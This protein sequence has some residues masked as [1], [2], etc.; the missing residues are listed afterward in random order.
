M[1]KPLKITLIVLSNIL[2]LLLIALLLVSPIAKSYIEKHD[3]ELIGRELTIDKLRV[4]LLGGKV[5]IKELTLFEDDGITP[6]VQF[7]HFET[8]IRLRDLLSHRLYVKKVLF[9]GLKVNVEQDRTW[10]NFNSLIEHFHSDEPKPKKEESSDF[11]LIF[12]DVTIEKSLIRYE[13]LSIGSDFLLRNISLHIPYIDLSNLKSQVGLDLI[14]AD[15]AKLHTDLHLSDNAEEYCINLKINNLG[16]DIIEPYLQQSLAVDSLQG[17]IDFDLS[18]EG[19]TEH[20]LDFDLT[21]D[22]ALRDL[23]LQDTCGNRLGHIDSIMAQIGRFNLNQNLLDFEKIYLSGLSSAYIVNADSTTNFDLFTGKKQ[24]S[25]TTI[26][27]KAIDTIAAEIEHIQER[28]TLKINIQDLQLANT[29]FSYEDHTLPDIFRYEITNI[30]LVSKNFNLNSNNSVRLTAL[31]NQVGKLNILWQGSLHGLENHNLTLMLSNVKF[32][33]FSPYAIRLFGFT[34]EDGTLSFNSQNII[35]N[36]NLQG[37]NKLQIASPAV[38]KKLKDV[39]PQYD[40]IPLKLGFYLLTDKHNNL[41]LD[42]PVSGN[43]NDPKFSYSK[44]LLKVFANLLVKVATSPFQLLASDDDIQYISFDPLQADFTASEYAMID[45]VAA[46][47][48]THDNLSIVMEEKVQYENTIQR[49]CNLQLQ[50]DYYLAQHPEIDST[51]IDFLTNEAIQSIKLNDNGLC[52]FAVQYSEKNKLRSKKDVASV[53][54]EVYHEKSER[55]F[56]QLMEHRNRQLS[57]YLQEIKGLTSEQISVTTID[58]SLLKSF[59]KSSRYELHIL[60]YEETEETP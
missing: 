37:I 13:D 32:T 19:R 55:L 41:N 7:N 30:G 17:R 18:A 31:L 9:S 3:K 12:N 47:L 24:H 49:L 22:I 59:E 16:L 43:L 29:H 21:G 11:G 56:P 8:K 57:H 38:G 35:S 26:F 4:N 25:D 34:L 52:D 58:D 14:L 60:E 46:M 36:G 1:K 39:E 42:L 23:S 2:G 54:Y 33:D 6:F 27:E 48:Y 45:E 20:I 10:F 53:A 28:K 15:S 40:N 44:A 5:V 51:G 50:R